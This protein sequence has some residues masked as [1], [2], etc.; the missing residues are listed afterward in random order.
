M[1]DLRLPFNYHQ[2]ILFV[3]IMNPPLLFAQVLEIHVI[4]CILSVEE[5][6]KRL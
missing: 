5:L 3:V 1:L 6:L 4:Q 2:Y